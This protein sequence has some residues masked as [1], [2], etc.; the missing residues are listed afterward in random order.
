MEIAVLAWGS[1]IWNPDNLQVRNPFAEGGPALPIEF[2]R[3]SGNGRLT[4]V[5]DESDGQV[6]NTYF[7]MSSYTELDEAREN[8]RVRENMKHVNGVGFVDFVSGEVSQR[9]L[10]RHPNAITVISRWAA[11][12]N[13]DAVIW[14]ALA[15]NFSEKLKRTFG[16]EEALSYL[17][18]LPRDSFALAA[19]YINSAPATVQT[20][21]RNAFNERWPHNG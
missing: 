10:E 20:Q 5:I 2:S 9:A 14:T 17:E 8:L 6:C 12:R 1:L 18:S 19:H 21:F 7:A 3:V 11:H 13:L 16:I 15:G 4:L